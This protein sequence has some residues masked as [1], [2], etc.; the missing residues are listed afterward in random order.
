[1][2]TTPFFSPDGSQVVFSRQHKKI[3]KKMPAISMKLYLI[4]SDGSGLRQLTSYPAG[5]TTAKWWNYHA[6]PPFWDAHFRRHKFS[7]R[8]SKGKAAFFAIRPDGSDFR[9]ITNNTFSGR[10]AHLVAR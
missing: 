4:N 3:L 9:R 1:M 6:G 8:S 10:L 7:T 2:P 5:D